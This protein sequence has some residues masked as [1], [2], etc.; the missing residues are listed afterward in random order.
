MPDENGLPTQAEVDAFNAE[1]TGVAGS[2]GLA[3]DDAPVGALYR[4]YGFGYYGQPLGLV[5]R[6]GLS[7]WC[8]LGWDDAEAGNRYGTGLDLHADQL[9]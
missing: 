2:L 3:A 7:F 6:P 1:T 8:L 4:D 9:S 5:R